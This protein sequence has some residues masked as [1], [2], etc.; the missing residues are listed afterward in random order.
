MKKLP[1]ITITNRSLK[2]NIQSSRLIDLH[3][4]FVC[5]Y[6]C[7]TKSIKVIKTLN[8]INKTSVTNDKVKGIH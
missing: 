3:T 4:I 6:F 2:I 1:I 7:H 5:L 8:K